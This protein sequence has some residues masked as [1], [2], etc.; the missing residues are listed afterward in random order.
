MILEINGK[1]YTII[2]DP[3]I[4]IFISHKKEDSNDAKKI[5]NF[6][7][8]C[9]DDILCYLDVLDPVVNRN[10]DD[11]GEYFR[12]ELGKCTHLMA[13]VSESTKL[14]WWVPFEIGIA[15]EKNYPIST[16]AMQSVD[17]PSYLKKWPYLRNDDDLESY[18]YSALGTKKDILEE[19][20]NRITASKRVS[21]TKA[22][23][24]D[25]KRRL[26]QS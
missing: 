13:V 11:L 10:G 4:K 1:K 6:L 3:L 12:N 20:L 26:G 7:E 24:K 2:K 22:F 23:H 15:T 17:L 21:Y 14:S 8:S 19:G 9:S 25:L 16:F 5:K 18:I